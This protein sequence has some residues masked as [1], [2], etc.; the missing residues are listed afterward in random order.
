MRKEDFGY[1]LRW[2]ENH[3]WYL[4]TINYECFKKSL[5][6]TGVYENT[7]DFQKKISPKRAFLKAF[8]IPMHKR[9][10]ILDQNPMGIQ[11]SVLGC[12]LD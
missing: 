4:T 2:N 7:H 5:E 1:L 3:F 11:L 10:L 6:N 12:H 9:P 8:Y